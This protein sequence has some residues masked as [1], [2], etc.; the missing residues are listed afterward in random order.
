[1]L[2]QTNRRTAG[3]WD[4]VL[5]HAARIVASYDTGVTLRQLFYRLVSDETLRNTKAEYAQLSARTA[6]AR[7]AGEYDLPPPPGKSADSRSAG[8]AAKYGSL[9]QVEVDALPP[10]VLRELFT[11]AIAD[12]WADDVYEAVLEREEAEREVL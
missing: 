4:E 3:D 7:R 9:F 12:Y 6:Q 8:F 10:D 1:M 11:A 2:T 5:D